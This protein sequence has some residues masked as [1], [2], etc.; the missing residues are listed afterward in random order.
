MAVGDAVNGFSYQLANNSEMDIRPGVGVE[1]I[2]HNLVFGAA[3]EVYFKYYDGANTRTQKI[4]I[5]STYG[6]IVDQVWHLSNTYW[7]SIKNVSGSASNFAY[8]G[9]ITK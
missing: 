7:L 2:I 5:R 4:D 9:I 3:C 1:W 6:A 8:N